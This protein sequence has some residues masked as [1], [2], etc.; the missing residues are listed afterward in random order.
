M[1]ILKLGAESFSLTHTV[2]SP[3]ANSCPKGVQANCTVTW[4]GD[5]MSRQVM[6]GNH[7]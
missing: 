4:E 1:N 5:F 3:T 7:F 2:D 6:G